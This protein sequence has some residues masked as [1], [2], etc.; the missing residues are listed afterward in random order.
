MYFRSAEKG[1]MD[2]EEWVEFLHTKDKV[3]TPLVGN[4]DQS[5]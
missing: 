5:Y 4:T 2:L 3:G 1:T